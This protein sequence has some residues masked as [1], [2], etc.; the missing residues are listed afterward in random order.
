MEAQRCQVPNPRPLAPQT[1]D[2]FYQV[3]STGDGNAHPLRS[4][5]HRLELRQPHGG[6]VPRRDRPSGSVCLSQES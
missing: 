6:L 3:I 1:R 5:S 4:S 2:N